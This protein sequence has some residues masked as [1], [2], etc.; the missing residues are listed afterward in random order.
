MRR[1][2]WHHT[3]KKLANERTQFSL[4]FRKL[5]FDDDDDE[6]A[7]LART[8]MAAD[9]NGAHEMMHYIK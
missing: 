7:S 8:Q 2:R 6:R 4:I 3:D 9:K 5:L 1:K